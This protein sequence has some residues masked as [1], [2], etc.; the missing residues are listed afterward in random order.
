[1]RY[2][3]KC[4][5][6]LLNPSGFD[7]SRLQISTTTPSVTN[8][9][10]FC[11][12]AEPI[13]RADLREKPRSAVEEQGTDHGFYIFCQN[14]GLSPD[15]PILGDFQRW[16][17]MKIRALF[18]VLF[19]WPLC[20]IPDAWVP[21]TSEIPG[22]QLWSLFVS[23]DDP[24]A[25]DADSF[26]CDVYEGEGNEFMSHCNSGKPIYISS[27]E[28]P[29]KCQFRDRT[30]NNAFYKM[31]AMTKDKRVTGQR[32]VVVST[33]PIPPKVKP[34]AISPEEIEKLK[35]A[36]RTSIAKY[37]RK[38][39]SQFFRNPGLKGTE[40]GY[41]EYVREIKSTDK[42]RKHIGARLKLPS[43]NGFIFVS[44]VGLD[45][46]EYIGWEIINVVYREIEGQMQEIGMFEGCIQGGFR[47]LNADG[48]PEVL[49]STCENGESVSDSYWALS[50][51]IMRVLEH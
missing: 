31:C 35:N 46:S 6:S 5:E 3:A 19:V 43:P 12:D 4:A 18:L 26:P 34:L 38:V 25:D 9:A 7:V 51:K 20:A 44:S 37:D 11:G 49:A 13:I 2:R 22:V 23:P 17:Y 27:L 29:V 45:S 10:I 8:G 21:I 36:E 14:G 48:T 24:S 32:L 1:M 39:K 50:P 42:Y 30:E 28:T 47:D 41:A 40:Q 16:A 15:S 33:R